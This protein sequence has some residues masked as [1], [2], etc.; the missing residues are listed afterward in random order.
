[1]AKPGSKPASLLNAVTKRHKRRMPSLTL[2]DR[3]V[4]CLDMRRKGLRYDEI[5]K[6]LG[7]SGVTAW[8]HVQQGIEAIITE[9]AK[10]VLAIE[11]ERIDGLWVPQYARATET[12]DQASVMACI[13]LMERRAKLLGLDVQERGQ[14]GAAM[15]IKPDASREEALAVAKA[16]VASLE[17]VEEVDSE[18]P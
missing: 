13:R 14:A 9:P 10:A 4:A 15:G 7:I 1:M 2:T 16:F 6:A 18:E 17:R 11:L 3:R 5:G 8:R 12:G